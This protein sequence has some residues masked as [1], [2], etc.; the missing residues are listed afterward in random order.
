M[1]EGRKEDKIIN[2]RKETKREESKE[3]RKKGRKKGR[4]EYV[5]DKYMMNVQLD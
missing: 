2:F 1:K 5:N 3:G 4:K